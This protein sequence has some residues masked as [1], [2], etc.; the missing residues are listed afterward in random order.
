M[1]ASPPFGSGFQ[2]FDS[3]GA[4]VKGL[5]AGGDVKTS[6]RGVLHALDM[7]NLDAAVCYLQVFDAADHTAVTLGT[8]APALVFHVPASGDKTPGILDFG[9]NNGLVVATTTTATGSTPPSTGLVVNIT[10]A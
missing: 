8:T 6:S 10:Y 1:S 5:G 9:F 3:A 4:A 7:S 2:A